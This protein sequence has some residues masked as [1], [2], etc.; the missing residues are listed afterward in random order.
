MLFQDLDTLV[1]Q[2]DHVVS[3][4][5]HHAQ[6]IQSNLVKGTGEMDVAIKSARRARRNKWICLGITILIILILLGIGLAL[7]KIYHLF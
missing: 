6:D 3:T 2:Q 7:G 1:I 4:I 5:E